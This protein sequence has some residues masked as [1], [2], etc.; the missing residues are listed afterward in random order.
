MNLV[1]V[2][3]PSKAKTI[4]KY[5]GK[6]YI[7]KASK[8]HVVDLPKSGLGIDVEHD[9]KPE[10][11]VTNPTSL[12][13]LKKSFKDADKLILAVDLD[14]EGEAIGW[15]IAKELNVIDENGKPKGKKP[16][17]RIVF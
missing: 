17:E 6:G 7:V 3:S 9:F 14:R 10:Y 16:F 15:H 8:G 11:I 12:S 2:E 1:V 13:E 4:G 5:L